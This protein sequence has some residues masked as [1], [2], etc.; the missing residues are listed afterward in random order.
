VMINFGPVSDAV[1]G[2]KANPWFSLAIGVCVLV[3]TWT[4]Y[5][6]H[7]LRE[8]THIGI[9]IGISAICGVFIATGIWGLLH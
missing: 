8:N 7:E 9:V 1:H 4:K 2:G 3:A 5:F 6:K